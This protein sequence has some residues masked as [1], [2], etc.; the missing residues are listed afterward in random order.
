MIIICY[1]FREMFVKLFCS[2]SIG[3]LVLPNCISQMMTE[4]AEKLW[5]VSQLFCLHFVNSTICL[6]FLSFYLH[7]FNCLFRCSQFWFTFIFLGA[8][9]STSTESSIVVNLLP[10]DCLW[11][12]WS[13][14]SV[15]L[16]YIWLFYTVG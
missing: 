10:T 3:V 7:F 1:F 8:S 13:D 4:H 16:F 9:T 6:H 15:F 12:E 2:L 11:S 14:W 5:K